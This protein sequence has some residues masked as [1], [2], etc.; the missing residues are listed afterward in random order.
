LAVLT[1]GARKVLEVR[2]EILKVHKI[3]RK[4]AMVDKSTNRKLEPSVL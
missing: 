4:L 3:A 2:G 1:G